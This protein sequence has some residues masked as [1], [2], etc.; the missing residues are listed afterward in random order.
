M[1]QADIHLKTQSSSSIRPLA[2]VLKFGGSV[3]GSEDDLHRL[4][5]EIYRYVRHSQKIIAV[6]SAFRGETDRLMRQAVALTEASSS[7]ALPSLIATGELTAS[8]LLAMACERSGLLTRFRT[9]QEIGFIAEGPNLHAK[10]L[11][12]D[13]ARIIQDL[14]SSDVLVVP[15]F[16]ASDDRG[17][18]ALLDRG[19]SDLTAV[20]IASELKVP[21]RLYK[22]VDGVYEADPA[23]MGS[24]VGRYESLDWQDAQKIAFPL[25]QA[26]A[27]AMAKEKGI[28]VEVGAL[29]YAHATVLGRPSALSAGRANAPLRLAVLGAGG[30][31]SKFL[32]RCHQWRERLDVRRVLVRDMTKHMNHRISERFT[33]DI[34]SFAREDV[35]VF[36]DI[37]A[38]V[39]PSAELLES[40]LRRGVGVTSANKQA[41]AAHLPNLKEAAKQGGSILSFAASVGG[42][43]PII[44]A[45]MR[46]SKSSKV[47]EM[48]GVLNGTSNFVIDQV[49]L[50]KSFDS[51]MDEARRLGF[52]EPD[53]TA[54]LDGTDVG[55]KLKILRD[56]AFGDL[57]PVRVS[58]GAIT[59]ESL[60]I[61]EGQGLRYVARCIMKPEGLLV[62]MSLEVLPLDHYLIGAVGAQNRAIITLA[63]GQ[64]IHVH[65]MGAGAWPTTE[66][67][68]A[69]VLAI[70]RGEPFGHYSGF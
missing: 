54:D 6:V 39:A 64:L 18:I 29:S 60:V 69:D 51:A 63:D 17:G 57:K 9:P 1:K 59:A 55:A 65:G 3:L 56:I 58:V 20:Y 47:V 68:F 7:S 70:G 12:L 35:D 24:A 5:S 44:E 25:V 32:E 22:D 52:A 31:G 66:A 43:A 8:S 67:L 53:S 10:P 11:K 13:Q 4:V 50:G 49:S 37:G 28:E 38:G 2:I 48:A 42:G 33:T 36:V 62:S 45:L 41:V 40:F 26:K 27:M 14:Q 15:G 19:G 61:P 34:R 16:L 30:V 23:I 46:A 21:V